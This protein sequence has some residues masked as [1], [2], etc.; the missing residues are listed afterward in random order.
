M[1]SFDKELVERNCML[2][3]CPDPCPNIPCTTDASLHCSQPTCEV[4]NNTFCCQ[5]SKDWD[6]TPILTSGVNPEIFH[7]LLKV[8]FILVKASGFKIKWV[9]G[10]GRD[11]LNFFKVSSFYQ[12]M[13]GNKAGLSRLGIAD[14]FSKQP[15]P[16]GACYLDQLMAAVKDRNLNI[17]QQQFLRFQFLTFLS[18]SGLILG[19]LQSEEERT[20]IL[21]SAIR[22]IKNKY[23]AADKTSIYFS[24]MLSLVDSTGEN[25]I[26]TLRDSAMEKSMASLFARSSNEHWSAKGSAAGRIFGKKGDVDIS[27]AISHKIIGGKEYAEL[28]KEIMPADFVTGFNTYKQMVC[29]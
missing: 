19:I 12:G 23:S 5:T 17:F 25:P 10:M 29:I 11:V 9:N 2:M 15:H 18:D 20:I 1:Y 21:N 3:P 7:N 13:K 22:F 14:T 28:V 6:P 27:K 8:V 4:C 24:V 26:K 16:S